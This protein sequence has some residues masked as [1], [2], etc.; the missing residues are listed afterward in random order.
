MIAVLRPFR[1]SMT[2]R[3]VLTLGI[4]ISVAWV[5]LPLLLVMVLPVARGGHTPGQLICGISVVR[6]LTGEP[7]GLARAA[8]RVLL[9]PLSVVPACLGLL[10]ALNDPLRRT[11]HDRCSGTVVLRGP[12]PEMDPTRCV[13]CGYDLRGSLESGRCPEC[14]ERFLAG[15][16]CDALRSVE[17]ERFC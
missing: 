2:D 5:A 15:V 10:T 4:G 14:G 11:W 9:L 3:E 16:A 7:A 17:E 1:E 6:E 13:H 12:H 8:G